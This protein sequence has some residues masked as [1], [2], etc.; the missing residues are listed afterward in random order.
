MAQSVAAA[1][2]AVESLSEGT[3]VW[4]RRLYKTVE[5]SDYQHF[6]GDVK[7]YKLDAPKTADEKK[8]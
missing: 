5:W 6:S 4:R 3:S 2:C 1:I 8:P 7:D